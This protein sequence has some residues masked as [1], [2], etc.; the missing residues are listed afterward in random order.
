MSSSQLLSIATFVYYFAAVFYFSA[1][2]FKNGLPGKLATIVTMFGIGLNASGIIL[3]W[4][5]SYRMGIGHA[6]L[7]NLYESLVFFSMTIAVLYLVIE[8]KYKNRAISAFASIRCNALGFP[9]LK[10]L[11]NPTEPVVSATICIND[12]NRTLLERL[13]TVVFFQ[14]DL[15]KIPKCICHGPY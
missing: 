10:T 4:V 7:S 1:C 11:R 6:P 12:S 9:P 2:I 13:H 14:C 8:F 3:R 5:E 15:A